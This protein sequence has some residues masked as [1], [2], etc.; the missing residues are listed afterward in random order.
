MG[1][2]TASSFSAVMSEGKDD[3]VMPNTLIDALVKSGCTASQLAA[4]VKVAKS[5][6]SNP[7]ATRS[8]YM[9]QLAGE[10]VRGEP[11]ESY[12]NEHMERGHEQEGAARKLYAFHTD[13]EP[14]IVGFVRNG[15]VGCSPDSLIGNDGGLEIKSA[16]AD[17]QI[18]RLFKNRLPPEHKAQVQGSLWICEREWWDFV[19]YCPKLPPLIVRVYRDEA[20]IA[21]L[22]AGV[23]K[24]NEEL[25]ALVELVRAYTPEPATAKAA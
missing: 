13:T 23:K 18:D 8:K 15:D 11:C 7:S 20:Y 24:F 22:A 12:T 4:A 16:L 9:R 19:S 17:I 3:G 2:P 21:S 10:V 6:N 5:K 25:A 14:Q 1:I